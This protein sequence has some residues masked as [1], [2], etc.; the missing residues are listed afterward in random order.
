M[1]RTL[2]K[3]L[4]QPSPLSP[5]PMVIMRTDPGQKQG[6]GP[7]PPGGGGEAFSHGS[8]LGTYILKRTSDQANSTLTESKIS[9]SF[10]FLFSVSALKFNQNFL[11]ND[12]R[13]RLGSA[14]KSLCDSAP[15]FSPVPESSSSPCCPEHYLL[16]LIPWG[17]TFLSQLTSAPKRP[18]DAHL[19]SGPLTT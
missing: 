2:W 19:R 9:I 3:A 16:S 10:Q 12:L 7:T 4:A 14:P 15:S 6:A 13:H 11:R 18:A 5:H 8:L 1:L 17:G